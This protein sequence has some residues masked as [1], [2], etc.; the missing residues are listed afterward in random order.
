MVLDPVRICFTCSYFG[1]IAGVEATPKQ[2]TVRWRSASAAVPHYSQ[3]DG[4]RW[5][6]GATVPETESG[7][8]RRGTGTTVPNYYAGSGWR[9]S[10]SAVPETQ[11]GGRW[12]SAG[13]AIPNDQ[14]G[15]NVGRVTPD[16]DRQ[17]EELKAGQG[18]GALYL[19]LAVCV[20]I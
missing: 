12:W 17:L 3:T 20:N 8:R 11:S 6:S 7:G 4:G 14:R 16:S 1:D 18:E 2:I 9:S 10:S 5:S 19:P 13:T 15:G